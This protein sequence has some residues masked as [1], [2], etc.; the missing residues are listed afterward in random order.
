MREH[1][2]MFK[3]IRDQLAAQER[4]DRMRSATGR[5]AEFNRQER[6]QRDALNRAMGF[7]RRPGQP[8]AVRLPEAERVERMRAGRMNLG[9]VAERDAEANR[10]ARE[11]AREFQE[12]IEARQKAR[13]AGA[14]PGADLGVQRKAALEQGERFQAELEQRQAEQRR[15][16]GLAPGGGN[17]APEA[18]KA[19]P[20]DQAAKKIDTTNGI[21]NRVLD[22]I[23]GLNLGLV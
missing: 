15:R 8:G 4:G 12:M 20:G 5:A 13:L 23:E 2:Q 7:G 9:P 14:A 16:A 3:Q 22:A 11:R 10:S 1:G 6:L 18:A 17:L 19:G 21:L